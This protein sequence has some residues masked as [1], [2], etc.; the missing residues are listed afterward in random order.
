MVTPWEGKPIVFCAP[1]PA[2]EIEDR[3]MRG[4]NNVWNLAQRYK[5]SMDRWYGHYYLRRTRF[6]RDMCWTVMKLRL[7]PDGDITRV[8]AT[9]RWPR[10]TTA[11]LTL[12]AA[13]PL[14]LTVCAIVYGAGTSVVPLVGFDL[15]IACWIALGCFL[16]RSDKALLIE[17]MAQAFYARTT[18][19]REA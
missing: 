12:V 17:F 4:T 5:I 2:H 14:V 6:F 18:T 8:H 7:E 10:W 3:M 16:A 11:F 9:F 1:L 13:V 19:S 15:A